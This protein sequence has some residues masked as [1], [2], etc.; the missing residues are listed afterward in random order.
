MRKRRGTRGVFVVGLVVSMAWGVGA[1]VP[2]VGD[3]VGVTFSGHAYG[4][5]V[6]VS[7]TAT[8][9]SDKT[10]PVRVGGTSHCGDISS[11]SPDGAQATATVA[12][13]EA[14]SLSTGTVTSTAV[15]DEGDPLVELDAGYVTTTS[16][17]EHVNILDGLITARAVHAESTVHRNLTTSGEESAFVD[18]VIAGLPV[19]ATV[20]PNTRIDLPA[21]LGYVVLNEQVATTAMSHASLSVVMLHVY[22]TDEPGGSADSGDQIVVASATSAAREFVPVASPPPALRGLAYGTFAQGRLDDVGTSFRSDRTFA[23]GLPCQ[24]TDGEVRSHTGAELVV[25]D[26]DHPFLRAASIRNTATGLV[27]STAASGATTSTIEQLELFG[28]LVRADAIHAA[29]HVETDNGVTTVHDGDSGFV[30]LTVDSDADGTADLQI[31]GST[32]ANT[33]IS[34]GES[35]PGAGDGWATVTLHRR[36]QSSAAIDVRMIEIRITGSN[37]FGLAVDATIVVA[38]ANVAVKA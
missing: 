12:T 18:L 30:N 33:T 10:A 4:T 11:P 8:F 23:I 19:A 1:P 28:G 9:K 34:L 7:S 27:S 31:T 24:G 21:G 37:P 20:P 16:T 26:E 5:S 2:A 35:S 22:L 36:R 38:A 13:V 15:I 25:L 17:V 14:P 29:A 3:D 6:F 32:P